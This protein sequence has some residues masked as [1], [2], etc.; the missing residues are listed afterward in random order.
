MDLLVSV[1]DFPGIA[2]VALPTACGFRVSQA[3]SLGKHQSAACCGGTVGAPIVAAA[4]AL[5]ARG[6]L[7]IENGI[8]SVRTMARLALLRPAITEAIESCKGQIYGQ[9]DARA[10]AAKVTFLKALV[11]VQ[12]IILKE[13]MPLPSQQSA[14]ALCM[15]AF[16]HGFA[17]HWLPLGPPLVAK[18]AAKAY[19][20]ANEA[21]L[22]GL[23]GEL[24][25]QA[26]ELQR[27]QQSMGERLDVVEDRVDV[28]EDRVSELEIAV[29]CI[30][31]SQRRRSSSSAGDAAAAA[32]KPA[33]ASEDRVAPP[34]ADT[35]EADT[36]EADT[37]E[38]DAPEATAPEAVAE[39]ARAPL[40]NLNPNLSSGSAAAPAACAEDDDGCQ[41]MAP[42]PRSP[43]EVVDLSGA[44]P[45]RPRHE[46]LPA[47]HALVPKL[48]ARDEAKRA[49]EAARY[50]N[51]LAMVRMRAR[52][53]AVL[54]KAVRMRRIFDA[55]IHCAVV[56]G[57]SDVEGAGYRALDAAGFSIHL[58][59]TEADEMRLLTRT[60]CAT[61]LDDDGEE[62]AVEDGFSWMHWEYS[63]DDDMGAEPA[64]KAKEREGVR[65][66]VAGERIVRCA[67]ALLVRRAAMPMDAA[68]LLRL[69]TV[70]SVTT[71]VFA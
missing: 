61:T 70:S 28:V 33:A 67:R 18:A 55:A 11:A 42:P 58:W 35:P 60:C 10:T 47:W 21:S 9:L 51:L 49:K 71:W 64:Y 66:M 3:R 43:P 45:P 1:T 23:V 26:K 36:P 19:A 34:E 41:E 48:A 24:G 22:P 13:R 59:D 63:L 53:N 4:N 12:T 50:R 37:L 20:D 16:A 17:H 52:E 7:P 57:A 15:T 39:A 54:M 25:L 27:V 2:L 46:P 56:A 69:E 14:A 30:Q 31:R 8:I 68:G 38:T 32:S 5:A 29:L 40:G 65:L 62:T 6:E 44:T